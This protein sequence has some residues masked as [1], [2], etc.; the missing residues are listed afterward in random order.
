MWDRVGSFRNEQR[1]NMFRLLN[2]NLEK[3]YRRAGQQGAKFLLAMRHADELDYL[4]LAAGMP[5]V[6]DA[7]SEERNSES[8]L[9]RHIRLLPI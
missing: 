9:A 3:S 7:D 2:R 5:T 1:K 4:S 8:M 6:S